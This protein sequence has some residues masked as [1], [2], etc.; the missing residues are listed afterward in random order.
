[1]AGALAQA[2][3]SPD[4]MHGTDALASAGIGPASHE[5]D[6]REGEKMTNDRLR[7]K[8]AAE[9]TWNP[10]VDSTDIT[11]SVE[12]GVVTLHGTVKEPPAQAR[13]G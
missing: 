6:D 2:G 9:L 7:A 5:A 1:M 10:R 11:V 4:S 3:N 8:V 12:G 13:G